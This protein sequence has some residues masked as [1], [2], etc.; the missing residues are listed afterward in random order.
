MSDLLKGQGIAERVASYLSESKG[1]PE[2][3]RV[4]LE[5]SLLKS[6]LVD[7]LGINDLIAFLEG[8]FNIQVDVEDMT[9][10][11]FDTV[12]AIAAFVERKIGGDG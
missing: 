12:A 2:E 6:G 11:N 8:T 5:T 10:D 4:E 1:L 9:P 3:D 7:S